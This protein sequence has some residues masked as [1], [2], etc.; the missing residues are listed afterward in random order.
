MS[1]PADDFLYAIKW[2]EK[3]KGKARSEKGHPMAAL[4]EQSGGNILTKLT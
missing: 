1:R 3:I 2:R 4:C